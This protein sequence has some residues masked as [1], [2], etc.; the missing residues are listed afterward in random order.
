MGRDDAVKVRDISNKWMKK[1]P[2]SNSEGLLINFVNLW[3]D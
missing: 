2:K 3:R 1:E